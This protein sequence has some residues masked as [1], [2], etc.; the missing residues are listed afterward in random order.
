MIAVGTIFRGN[1]YRADELSTRA[2]FFLRCVDMQWEHRTMTANNPA[3]ALL[4]DANKAMSRNQPIAAER[5]LTQLLVL[6]PDHVEANRLMGVVSLMRENPAR[7]IDFLRRALIGRPDDATIHMNLGSAL[8]QRGELDAGLLSLQQ[9]CDLAPD[10]ASAWYNLGR[11]LKMKTR[12][13]EARSAYEHAL[14]IDPA[15]TMSRLNLADIQTSLGDISDAVSS[16]RDILRRQ[17]DN[18]KAWYSLAN[19]KTEPFDKSDVAQIELAL[20]HPRANADSRIWLG[21]ALAKALEDQDDYPAAFDALREANATKRRFVEWNVSGERALADAILKAFAEPPPP[22]LDPALG[23]EVIF[24]VSLPRSGSTLTEQILASHPEVEGANEIADL[25]QVLNDESKRRG[26][27]FPLWVD[28][29]TTEDWSRLGREY[30]AR[31]EWWRRDKPRFTDKNL[32]TWQLVGAILRMLPGARVVNSRRN[33][34]ETCFACYRQLF[35]D[36]AHFSYDLDATVD[37]YE[38]YD[39]LSRHWQQLFPQQ[40][41]THEYELLQAGPEE[42]IRRL[43]DFCRLEFNPACLAFHQTSRAV[44]STAS[45]AQ[46]RQPL[47]TDTARTSRYGSKLDPLRARLRDSGLLKP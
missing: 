6:E 28:T 9:A 8:F 16:Y 36:G 31:T 41:F 40:F 35:S 2:S 44:L 10:M 3:S 45:A 46:V 26:M 15:H 22:P 32:V 30:L 19:L 13:E 1:E 5:T 7:A 47:R 29:T 39:R 27:P 33:A 14:A 34:L 37:Y 11:A 23:E 17:P 38:D 24:I 43:L 12:I 25:P 20:R 18:P 42:Q 4:A 21:F